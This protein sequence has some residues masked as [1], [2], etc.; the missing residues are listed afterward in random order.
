[1]YTYNN[2][3]SYESRVFSDRMSCIALRIR[4]CNIIVLNAHT[5]SQ[6]K[7]DDFKDSFRDEL[8]QD[9]VHFLEYNMKLNLEDFS[10]KFG[11]EDIFKTTIG[12]ESL[13]QDINDSGKYICT[14]AKV[15]THNQTDHILTD[16]R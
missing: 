13:H 14:S 12:N 6:E 9:C 10:E 4:L 1:M 15:M 11:R 2:I 3:G 5:P 7:S 16:R 8:K